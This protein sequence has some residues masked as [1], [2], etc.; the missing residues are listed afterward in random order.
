VVTINQDVAEDM[1]K[2]QHEREFDSL[3]VHAC[4]SYFGKRRDPGAERVPDQSNIRPIFSHDTD[5]IIHSLAYTRYIDKTQVFYL[6]EN[7]HITHRVL[8]VQMVSKIARSIGR[9]L[10]LNEDLIEAIS[11]G[12]DVGHSPFGH[13]GE[14]HLQ[15]FCK[16]H[17]IGDF[18]HNAQSC[19]LLMELENYGR[20]L[21]L[22][23]QVLDGILCHNG[24]IVSSQ[25]TPA[26]KKKWN[27]FLAEYQ[28]C[29]ESAQ[30]SLTITPMTLEGCVVRISDVIAYIGRDFE[31]A[32]K[33]KLIKRGDLPAE[34]TDILGKK[35][36]SVINSLVTDL[37]NNSY[38]KS[39]IAFSD[40]VYEALKALMDFNYGN[41]YNNPKKQKQDDKIEMMF[42]TVL[43]TY[44]SD[45][46]SSNSESTI[47]AWATGGFRRQYFTGTP[48]PRIVVDFVS[49]MTDD[50]LN[51]EY[52]R[53][54]LPK[55][56][57][58]A[59]K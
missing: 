45:L 24:E 48:K 29:M 20:G 37:L 17:Q 27:E 14:K 13:N 9:L 4:R 35:N 57:G 3:S 59:F 43:R 54:I 40:S 42:L 28:R 49:G 33:L 38:K 39:Y 23:L 32:I 51:S 6:I 18:A 47:Y 15:E 10:G 19:R 31:D 30:A 25:Y 5:R 1:I 52:Q 8:H 56:F 21:N 44:L 50:F 58:Y 36:S 16:K 46:E 34:A 53:M 26:P 11:L 12:H 7:D 22:T 41:I 2:R 55:S